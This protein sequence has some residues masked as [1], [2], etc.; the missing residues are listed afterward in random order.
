MAQS[1]DGGEALLAPG[2]VGTEY[3]RC[4]NTRNL[5]KIIA[6]TTLGCFHQMAKGKKRGKT[7]KYASSDLEK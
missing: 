7:G 5:P 1:A 2:R 3:R 4:V 6:C